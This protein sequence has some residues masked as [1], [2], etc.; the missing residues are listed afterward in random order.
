M[1]GLGILAAIPV[2]GG[3]LISRDFLYVGTVDARKAVLQDATSNMTKILEYGFFYENNCF[4]FVLVC[5]CVFLA[6]FLF[7][8]AMIPWQWSIS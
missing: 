7:S 3:D 2:T 5:F 6:D 8:A 4:G 1:R